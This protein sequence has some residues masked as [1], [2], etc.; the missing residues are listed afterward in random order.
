[1]S[2]AETP[3]QLA[4]LAVARVT[5]FQAAPTFEGFQRAN[6]DLAAA[7]SAALVLTGS[8][9]PG[10]HTVTQARAAYDL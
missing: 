3:S 4:R 8:P 7:L 1:M 2:V 9:T 5:T 6:R 10:P